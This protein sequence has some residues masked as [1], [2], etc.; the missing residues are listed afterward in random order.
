MAQCR[1]EDAVAAGGCLQ[2]PVNQRYQEASAMPESILLTRDQLCA[3]L[4]I[5]DTTRQRL[6][7]S[8]PAFP[9]KIKIGRR[10]VGYLRSDVFDYIAK[11]RN[12]A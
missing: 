1:E 8:D 11:Q 6:E 9:K 4:F 7:K 10:K 12:A 5:S 2:N 3:T